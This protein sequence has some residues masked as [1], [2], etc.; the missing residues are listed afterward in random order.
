MKKGSCIPCSGSDEGDFA[1]LRQCFYCQTTV[2]G[3]TTVTIAFSL[4]Y[5]KIKK[6]VYTVTCSLR[7]PFDI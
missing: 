4:D 6:I 1:G 3:I 7:R 2:L 5:T